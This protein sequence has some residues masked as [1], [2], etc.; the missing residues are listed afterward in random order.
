MHPSS[1]LLDPDYRVPVPDVGDRG[2]AWLRSHVAR[3]SEGPDHV[4]RRELV[5]GLLS[6]LDADPRPGEDPTACLLRTLGRPASF[7]ADVASI[8]LAYH[9]HL[10]TT[11]E[12][13]A[14]VERFV[15]EYGERSE[16]VAAVICV[17]VQ[18]HAGTH[19]LI[20]A[21]RDGDDRA[22]VPAT[23]RIAPGG[24]VVEVDLADAHFGRGAHACPGEALG[25]RLA[26][27]ALT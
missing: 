23:R 7:A 3:F 9:P 5:V 2:M 27:A 17:L 1:T 4:R 18:A 24:E 11:P 21:L 20:G 10:P 15:D 13:D 22:P 6:D 25:R 16:T 14:A 8:A 19:A 12:A 26:E